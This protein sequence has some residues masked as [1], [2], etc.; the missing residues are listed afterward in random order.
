MRRTKLQKS[1][2]TGFFVLVCILYLMPIFIVLMN[3][4]KTNASINTATFAF[5]NKDV[6]L[7]GWWRLNLQAPPFNM[8]PPKLILP[9]DDL[10]PMTPHNP[11]YL[12]L[13]EMK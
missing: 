1:V 5:P 10:D 9:E 4:F 13:W 8:S 6:K 11:G 7:G 3:S 2:Q 12:A